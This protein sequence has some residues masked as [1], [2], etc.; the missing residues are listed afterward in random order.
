MELNKKPLQY[1]ED[2]LEQNKI[3]MLIDSFINE[4]VEEFGGD[5]ENIDYGK[6]IVTY[7]NNYFDKNTKAFVD[8]ITTAHFEEKLK[9]TVFSEFQK[10]KN[11]IDEY[12]FNNPIDYLPI[13]Y[14]Q[15]K[16]LQFLLITGK[17]DIL[18][19]PVILK[20]IL[21]MQKYINEKYLYNQDKKISLNLNNLE[22]AQ[23]SETKVYNDN[24]SI[25]MIL[26]YLKGS[27]DKRE[28]IMSDEQYDLMIYYVT[29][30]V[31][32]NTIPENLQK[33]KPLKITGNL[34]RFTFWVLHKHLY[35]TRPIKSDFLYLIQR[36]FSNFDNWEFYTLKSKFASKEKVTVSGVKFIPEIIKSEFT[37]DL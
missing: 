34:L 31:E 20:P 19:F 25:E 15:E 11:L 9:N 13:L 30:Y 28:K 5:I 7:K 26:G 24:D 17:I 8:G 14:L 3:N 18:K 16:T 21:G 27:N 33:L 36:L 1:F 32:N 23:L 37:K 6:G 2:L 35:T 29:S 4:Y 22:T 10:S 12:V